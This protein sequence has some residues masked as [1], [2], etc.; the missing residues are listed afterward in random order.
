MGQKVGEAGL[1]RFVPRRRLTP[2]RK[3]VREHGAIALAV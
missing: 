2:I 1:D 3:R